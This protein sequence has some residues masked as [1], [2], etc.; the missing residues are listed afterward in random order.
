M[1]TAGDRCVTPN[2]S[3][4]AWSE[5]IFFIT[6][7]LPKL[8]ALEREKKKIFSFALLSFFHNFAAG[9]K[10]KE[11][12]AKI[13]E[14]LVNGCQRFLDEL[15]I[16]ERQKEEQRKEEERKAARRE[17]WREMLYGKTSKRVTFI[18]PEKAPH[19]S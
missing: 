8:M 5:R 17:Y 13:D 15:K 10:Q 14:E 16:L 18:V 4:S 1:Y 12:M 19:S 3:S 6:L 9:K 11:I 7:A 2:N